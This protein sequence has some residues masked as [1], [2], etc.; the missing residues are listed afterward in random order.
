MIQSER[1]RIYAKRDLENVGYL[2]KDIKGK[3]EFPSF[4]DLCVFT[5]TTTKL[6]TVKNNK[7]DFNKVKKKIKEWKKE[8]NLS[9]Q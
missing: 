4:F 1:V 8:S 2:V 9:L 3:K 7:T 6:V 5:S